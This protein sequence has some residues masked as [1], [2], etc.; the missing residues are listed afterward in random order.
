MLWILAITASDANACDASSFTRDLGNTHC[1]A[2]VKFTQSPSTAEECAAACC[3]QGDGCET[4]QLCDAGTPCAAGFNAMTGALAAG[5]DLDGW[6]RND[7][8]DVAEAACLANASCVGLTY[9]SSDLHPPKTT[10][11]KLYL[12]FGAGSTG[13]TSWS[14][15][16]KGHAGCFTGILDTSCANATGWRSA[17]LKPRPEGPCDILGAA[18]TPCVAAH[19]VGRALY[20]NYTGPLSVTRSTPHIPG[21]SMHPSRGMSL[22][23]PPAA[24]LGQGRPRHR[25]APQQRSRAQ[26]G[27]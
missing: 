21:A 5:K 12:K 4:W 9:H 3:S 8:I 15:H 20:A 27:P 22:Q 11:L 6:P 14:R 13:D 18:Q 25:R 19:S 16:M 7:T 10:V 24:R 1:S 23:V 17:A 26:G 2:G